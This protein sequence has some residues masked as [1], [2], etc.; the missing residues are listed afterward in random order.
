MLGKACEKFG[1]HGKVAEIVDCLAQQV[2]S[3]SLV[4]GDLR[5]GE[6]CPREFLVGKASKGGEPLLVEQALPCKT[7]ALTSFAVA[8]SICLA[9]SSRV[10]QVLLFIG[11][12]DGKAP[13]RFFK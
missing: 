3:V 1:G 4:D 2:S 7:M 5:H 13:A 11:E 10:G 9:T 6:V 8:S 12:R